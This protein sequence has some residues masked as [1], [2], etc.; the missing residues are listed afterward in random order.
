VSQLVGR[1]RRFQATAPQNFVA[2]TFSNFVI[3]MGYATIT[4]VLPLF[5]ASLGFRTTQIGFV[6][7]SY[8]AARL[9]LD[10]AG[11]ML[12]DRLGFR[13]VA[14]G[15]CLLVTAG[16][17]LSAL[18]T[19][20]A[21]LLT[22]QIIAGVGSAL[23][24]IAAFTVIILLA[25]PL[26][27]ARLLGTYHTAIIVA[28]SIGPVLG[29]ALGDV[30]SLR[31][32]FYAFALLAVVAGVTSALWIPASVER[33]GS[34]ETQP[35]LRE[36][37]HQLLTTPAFVISL[38]VVSTGYAVRSG[39]RNTAIPMFAVE[40]LGMTVAMVGVLLTAAVLT[41]ALLLPHAGRS[42]DSTGRRPIT[43]RSM[44]AN[45]VMLLVLAFVGELWQ[46][47][48]V[49]A[50]LGAVSAYSGLAPVAVM[51]DVMDDDVRPGVTV[52]L[53]R[54]GVDLGMVIGPLGVGFGLQH[55]GFRPTF[56][57][58]ALLML[59]VA[60]LSFLAPESARHKQ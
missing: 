36:A 8:G 27:K 47:F 29:G 31:A 37:L 22:G 35:G 10:L 44:A 20:F 14:V 12:G 21:T 18:A 2:I 26:R 32:P 52:G 33:S 6:V 1:V 7:A 38:L 51:A 19:D 39:V 50:L 28:F 49:V 11:G 17:L 13:R 46:L 40:E 4:P 9:L 41:N 43:I 25:D 57:L 3:V 30:I 56:L 15:G 16:A 55:V 60:A 5:G 24:T 23:Y 34:P 53:Q 42:L 58:F 59:I 48:A 45:A 54:M